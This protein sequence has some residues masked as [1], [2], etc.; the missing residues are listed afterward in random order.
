MQSFNRM[1]VCHT[2]LMSRRTYKQYTN[3]EGSREIKTAS[4]RKRGQNALLNEEWHES[5]A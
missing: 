4:T 2:F 1:K 5:P 3:G